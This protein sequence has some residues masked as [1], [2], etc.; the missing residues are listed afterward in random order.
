MAEVHNIE[1]EESFQR[2]PDTTTNFFNEPSER[3]EERERNRGELRR[4]LGQHRPEGRRI[5]GSER[6]KPEEPRTS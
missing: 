2:E 3:R 1:L 6:R 5:C 4:E